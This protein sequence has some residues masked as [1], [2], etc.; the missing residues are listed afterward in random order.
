MTTGRTNRIPAMCKLFALS[1]LSLPLIGCSD[2]DDSG[3]GGT[4]SSYSFESRFQEGESSVSYSGQIFRHVL[5]EDLKAYIGGLN[6]AIESDSDFDAKDV[7]DALLSFYEFDSDVL[8]QNSLLLKTDPETLQEVYDDISS[9]KDLAGK[10][11]GQDS[12]GERDHKD[13]AS[14]FEGWSDESVEAAGGDISNPDGLV[15]AWLATIADNAILQAQGDD[16]RKGL[17]PYQTASGQDLQQLTQ[18]FLLGAIAFSQAADDYLDEGLESDN[19]EQDEENPYTALEHAWDEGFGYFG[20]AQRYLDQS[21]EEIADGEIFDADEDG[22]TDLKSE[23]NFG[24]S[25]NAAKRDAGSTSGTD[26]TNMAMA[27]FLEGRQLIASG[28]S[29]SAVQE[30]AE[31]AVAAWEK[32]LA[33]T[34][35]HYI[36]DTLGDMEA[37]GTDE[38]SFDDHAKHWSELKGFALSFQFNPRSPLSEKRFGQLHDLIGD[39]PVLDDASKDE[40]S[41]YEDALLEARELLRDAYEFAVED[42]ENW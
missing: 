37:M 41:D 34:A 21:D 18:K 19:D 35:V 3:P 1:C 24:A 2:D 25:V 10:V 16:S 15:R 7:E 5:I 26:F 36:N 30:Q 23:F 20:A 29:G 32:S 39:G 8:G 4:P 13:W 31:Q 38:Y 28:K 42:V 9:D 27:A 40:L 14:E 12:A 33:A 22:K 11:A 6:E 17:L